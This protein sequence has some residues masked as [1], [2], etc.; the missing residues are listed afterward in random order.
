M[1]GTVLTVDPPR[2]LE[3]TRGDERLRFELTPQGPGTALVFTARFADLGRAARDGA[4]RHVCLELLGSDLTGE[5]AA[6]PADA[7]WRQVIGA[8]QAAFGP[9]ASVEGPPQEWHDMYAP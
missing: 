8:Y 1:D 5:P 9:A 3:Y 4:G 7:R 2:L 6:W